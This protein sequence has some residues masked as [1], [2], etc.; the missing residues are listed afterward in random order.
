MLPS[1]GR[2]VNERMRLVTP[3]FFHWCSF[4]NN[5]AS[6]H[7]TVVCHSNL[8]DVK[9]LSC[10]SCSVVAW[11]SL[12][13]ILRSHGFI[14][15]MSDF[16]FAFPESFS[17]PAFQDAP[18]PSPSQCTGLGGMFMLTRAAAAQGGQMKAMALE[19]PLLQTT[20][21]LTCACAHTHKH[22]CIYT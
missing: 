10:A 3:S 9:G 22:E 19:E 4:V 18:W 8:E 7:C 2:Q 21:M 20:A 13:T 6:S 12:C 14:C 1:L 16:S 5:K 17:S 11:H 15:A